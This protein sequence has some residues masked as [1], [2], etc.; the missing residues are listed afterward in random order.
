MRPWSMWSISKPTG[1]PLRQPTERTTRPELG[2]RRRQVY[3]DPGWGL[4]TTMERSR[5]R[6]GTSRKSMK[7]VW[8]AAGWG[9]GLVLLALSAPSA[10][11]V[12]TDRERDPVT[13]SVVVVNPSA[14]RSQR[15]PVRIELPQEITPNDV[16]EKGEMS[17]EY[18]DDRRV[19]YVYK[20]D[21]ELK[22]KETRVFEVK[23]R[24]LWAVPQTELDSLRNYTKLLL[25]RIEHTEYYP[26]AKQLADS[27]YERLQNIQSTQDDETLSRKTRI[28]AYRYHRQTIEQIKEDLSRMEKLLT[29]AGGP[30]VPE[31]LDKSALRS[32]GPSKTTTWL[33]IFLV[34]IFVGLLG[35]QFFFTWHRRSQVSD[36]LAIVRQAAFPSARQGAGN[37]VRPKSDGTSQSGSP[38]PPPLGRR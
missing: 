15:V 8:R 35:A 1:F 16:I 23:V 2:A 25:G 6:T 30:P 9:V 20:D 24:D 3:S 26:T 28:G 33:I 27:V 36:E 32:D 21:I 34:L 4:G 22:P 11:A 12:T 5:S 14:E 18:D 37:G 19:Y 7:T 29:F 13:L 17:L 10:F 31:M 38:T